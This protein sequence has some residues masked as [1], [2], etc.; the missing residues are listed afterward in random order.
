MPVA[1]P[2]EV[3]KICGENR[4]S[5]R[6]RSPGIYLSGNHYLRLFY[7]G[8]DNRASIRA[9]FPKLCFAL[10]LGVYITIDKSLQAFDKPE[11][12]QP[13]PSQTPRARKPYVESCSN[14]SLICV[15]WEMR[16]KLHA[17]ELGILICIEHIHQS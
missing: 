11:K 15:P 3:D 12:Y 17:L 13:F 5:F 10:E 4:V 16:V 1:Y 14:L 7:R 2:Y 8:C 9:P 6:G